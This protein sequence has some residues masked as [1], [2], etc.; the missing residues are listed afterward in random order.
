MTSDRTRL[1]NDERRAQLLA[2][3]RRLFVDQPYDQL[4]VDEVARRAG[5]S[6]GLLYHYFPSKRH[7][8]LATVRDAAAALA[9]RVAPDRSLPPLEQLRA[10]LTGYLDYVEANA[11]GYR[12]LLRGSGGDPEVHA[13]VERTRGQI[14]RHVL[15][16]LGARRARPVLRL[17]LRGWIGFVEGAVLDWLERRDARREVLLGLMTAALESALASAG[18]RPY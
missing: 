3:G 1:P 8:Y 18:E 11:R 15:G 2:L 6:K 9:S 17:A 4:S 12:A 13:I 5:I 10:S 7:F 16:A 14:L